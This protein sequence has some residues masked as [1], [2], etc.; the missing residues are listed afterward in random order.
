MQDEFYSLNQ[1]IWIVY[2]KTFQKFKENAFT[3]NIHLGALNLN[4]VSGQLQELLT[5]WRSTTQHNEWVYVCEKANESVCERERERERVRVCVF[6]R[7]LKIYGV[8]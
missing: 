1:T 3:L 4:T 2:P 8:L 7:L 5:G 6:Y